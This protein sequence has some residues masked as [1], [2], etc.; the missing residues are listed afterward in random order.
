MRSETNVFS[1]EAFTWKYLVLLV[2]LWE[3][4]HLN[5][6]VA[7]SVPEETEPASCIL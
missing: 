7:G 3:T 4:E 2:G 1:S 6:N 5:E